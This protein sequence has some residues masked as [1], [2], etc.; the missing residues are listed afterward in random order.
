MPYS[1]SPKLATCHIYTRVLL[2][3]QLSQARCMDLPVGTRHTARATTILASAIYLLACPDSAGS[4]GT[5]PGAR[6][7]GEAA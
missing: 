2:G 3:Y 1:L 6:A 7:S 5:K 4:G